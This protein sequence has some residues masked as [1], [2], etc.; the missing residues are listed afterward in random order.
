MFTKSE[1]FKKFTYQWVQIHKVQWYFFMNAKGRVVIQRLS[2]F[3]KVVQKQ[4]PKGTELWLDFRGGKG[5]RN[6]QGNDK[7]FWKYSWILGE[8]IGNGSTEPLGKPVA[9]AL[10]LLLCS[11][12]CVT[13]KFTKKLNSFVQTLNFITVVIL[14]S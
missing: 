1:M 7:Y 8:G 13:V 9:G 14:F 6:L 10:H 4:F 2:T 12:Y 3:S 5:L 11:K